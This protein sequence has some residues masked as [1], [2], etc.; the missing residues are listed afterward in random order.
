MYVLIVFID[1]VQCLGEKTNSVQA[2]KGTHV[3]SCRSGAKWLRR[4]LLVSY[5]K[6][7]WIGTAGWIGTP[8]KKV[9]QISIF[10]NL[11]IIWTVLFTPQVL[12]TPI[13]ST[14]LDPHFL[15]CH[16]LSFFPLTQFVAYIALS[17]MLQELSTYYTWEKI[18][19]TFKNILYYFYSQPVGYLVGN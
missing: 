5:R 3:S 7:G 16:M 19:V 6:S 12:F 15:S 11:K 10:P 18:L 4:F 2:V 13:Y 17:K 1:N 8:T 9:L 14:Q